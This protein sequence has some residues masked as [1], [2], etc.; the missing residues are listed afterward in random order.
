MNTLFQNARLLLPDCSIVEGCLG[1]KENRIDFVGEQPADFVA[2][3]TIDCEGNLLLPGFVNAHTHVPMTLFRSEADDYNLQEWL[4]QHIFPLEDQLTEEMTYWASSLA[5]A[6]MLRAG[7]TSFNDMYF[8][9]DAI[10]RAMADASVRGVISRPVVSDGTS[11]RIEE[12]REI[13]KQWHGAENDRIHISM[14]PHAE[15]TCED[16]ELKAVAEMAREL[17]CRIHVHVSESFSEHEECKRKHGMTPLQ[18]LNSFGLITSKSML[19][20][21][22]HLELD[23][24]ALVTARNAHILHCP[25][26]NLKLG[27]GVAPIPL[28][29]AQKINIALGTDGAASNNNLDL[30]E[31]LRLCALIHKGVTNNATA[32]N[33]KQAISM[34]TRG[35]ALALGLNAGILRAGTLADIIMLDVSAPHMMPLRNEN[36]CAHVA[37]SAQSS[38]VLLTMIDGNVLY[39][40]GEFYTLDIERI[41]AQIQNF[42]DQLQRS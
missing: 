39:E 33:A 23:D 28:Y 9:T 10:A 29:M 19:A 6:E 17:D 13:Y 32:V 26:S 2:Q 12:A 5:F 4:F 35:G 38:D 34:A 31:E 7:I 18:R 24:V 37:Y 11:L 21:C 42:S 40:K 3:R 41:R 8:F 20:H 30:L 27:S 15:Y 22:V 36:L 1:V 14:A 25:Q 16:A